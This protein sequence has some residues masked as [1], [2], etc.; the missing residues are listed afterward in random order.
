MLSCPH[1]GRIGPRSV[2]K[3]GRKHVSHCLRRLRTSTRRNGQLINVP[4]RIVEIVARF[5]IDRPNR[6][7]YLRRERDIIDRNDLGEQ[8]G[9]WQLIHAGIE[10]DVAQQ[11]LAERGR[12]HGLC[13][14]AEASP[15]IRDRAAAIRDDELRGWEVVKNIGGQQLHEPGGFAVQ[16]MRSRGMECGIAGLADMGGTSSSV[17]FS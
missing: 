11:M 16:I 13:Q 3:A 1:F 14:S 10:Q 5:R 9:A 6:S 8:L 15:M 12:L 2:S 4:F 17:I 7:D